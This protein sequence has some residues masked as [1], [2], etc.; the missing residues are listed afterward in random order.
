M[1]LYGVVGVY[2]EYGLS[3]QVQF[4]THQYDFYIHWHF[5]WSRSQEKIQGTIQGTVSNLI[6]LYSSNIT[7]FIDIETHESGVTKCTTGGACI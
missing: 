1:D 4:Y 7:V 2:S 3:R 6:S 5:T